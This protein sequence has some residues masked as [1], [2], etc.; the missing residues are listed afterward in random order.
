MS[1]LVKKS[2]SVGIDGSLSL[3]RELLNSFASDICGDNPDIIVDLVQIYLQ[4]KEDLIE[5]ITSAWNSKDYMLLRRAAHS[6]K[7]SSRVFGANLLADNC[8]RLEEAALTGDLVSAP[9]LIKRIVEQSQQMT[10]LLAAEF[11]GVETAK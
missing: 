11:E 3:D 1:Y 6:L 10:R 8:Q 4:S 5:Q 9:D 7:S 2:T